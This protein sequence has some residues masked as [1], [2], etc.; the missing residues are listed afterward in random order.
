MLLK[1]IVEKGLYNLL[2]K[3][4]ES[5]LCSFLCQSSSIQPLSMLFTYSFDSSVLKN[6]HNNDSSYVSS[7]NASISKFS[8]YILSCD[9]LNNKILLLHRRFGHHNSQTL[10]HLLKSVTS[11]NLSSNIIK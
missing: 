2:L 3:P 1:G 6:T 9:A 4:S 8:S 7:C 5:I 10:M 11:V